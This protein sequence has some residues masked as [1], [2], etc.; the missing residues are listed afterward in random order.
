MSDWR[1]IL[2]PALPAPSSEPSPSEAEPPARES[3][4]EPPS[5]E[6]RVRTAEIRL[7]ATEHRMDPSTRHGLR[8]S[9]EYMK[10]LAAGARDEVVSEQ[11][12][13]AFEEQL[14]REMT[15]GRS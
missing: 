12:L 9:M 6:E 10:E 1:E 7:S 13:G 2:G 15:R 14:R 5:F 3:S 11:M 4:T 8:H